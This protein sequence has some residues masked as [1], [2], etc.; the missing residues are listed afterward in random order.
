[1]CTAGS[2]LL[3]QNSVKE[4]VTRRIVEIAG[5]VKLGDPMDPA[6]QMGPISNRPQFDKV[7]SYIE[8]ARED[9]ARLIYGGGPAR[10]TGLDRGTFIEPTVFSDVTNDM[11][12]AQE[13]VFGPVLSIIGFEDEAEAIRIANDINFGFGGGGWTKD[14]GRMIRMVRAIDAGT[15]WGNTYR[16]YSFMVPFGGRKR[17][18]IGR[19]WGIEGIHDFLETKSVMISTA[20]VMPGVYPAVKHNVDAS[21]RPQARRKLFGRV[22]GHCLPVELAVSLLLKPVPQKSARGSK[23]LPCDWRSNSHRVP[24]RNAPTMTRGAGAFSRRRGGSRGTQASSVGCWSGRA[25]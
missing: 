4:D 19:E 1:M 6:T 23:S 13:E 17:S 15:V 16:T 25:S 21:D 7:L 18:G 22:C 14:M 3:V 9:G 11:R 12:I 20:D 5:T 10:G 2:R 24:V 8:V